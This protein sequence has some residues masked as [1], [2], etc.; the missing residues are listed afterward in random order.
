MCTP[1]LLAYDTPLW[2]N[3]LFMNACSLT[4]FCPPLIRERITAVG[5]PLEEEEYIQHVAHTCV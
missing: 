1:D 3:R 2:H 5:R 4:Y